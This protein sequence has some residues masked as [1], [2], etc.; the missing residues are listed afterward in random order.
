MQIKH[1][2]VFA[3]AFDVFSCLVFFYLEN[4]LTVREFFLFQGIFYL[5]SFLAEIPVGYFADNVSKKNC[6]IFSFV[7]FMLINCIWLSF[8][9]AYFVLIGEILFAISKVIMDNVVAGYLYDYLSSKSIQHQ[10]VKYY[11][12]TNFYLSAGTVLA[13]L[14]G[15]Y[16]YSKFGFSAVFFGEI[17]LITVSIILVCLLPQ[18]ETYKKIKHSLKEKFHDFIK[19][20]TSF[21][22]QDKIKYYVLYSGLLTS[23]SILF[24]LS[25]QHLM[26]NALLPIVFFGIVAFLNHGIRA[27]AS[28]FASKIAHLIKIK[29][30]IIPLFIMYILAFIFIFTI[31]NIKNFSMIIFLIF[32]I[33]VIIGFQLLFTICHISRLHKF[34]NTDDRGKIMMFN[35]LFSKILVSIVL[36]S[37]IFIAKLGFINYYIIA[38]IVMVFA[39]FFIT[40]N[41][42]KVKED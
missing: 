32:L 34:V 16:I 26:Q 41:L 12:Y 27:V 30:M 22:K 4:D 15:T 5:T 1:C 42:L 21:Y 25:F 19:T 38:F 39:C 20:S 8:R 31:A 17:M 18:I 24:S 9:G 40:K 28:I 14:F 33:C 35:N 7:I 36:I 2:T 29:Q 13:S 37:N 6:L 11:G 3:C 23:Y 10:M